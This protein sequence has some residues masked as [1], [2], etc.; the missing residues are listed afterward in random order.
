MPDFAFSA[1]C[2]HLQMS[3]RRRS[4]VHSLRRR[5]CTC[6][7]K[8]PTATPG[9]CHLDRPANSQTSGYNRGTRAAVARSKLDGATIRTEGY[10]TSRFSNAP[11]PSES[12]A[13]DQVPPAV[14]LPPTPVSKPGSS[15]VPDNSTRTRMFIRFAGLA[16]QRAPA[17]RSHQGYVSWRARLVVRNSC[18]FY[19]RLDL[20]RPRRTGHSVEQPRLPV[21]RTRPREPTGFQPI[22]VS[23]VLA[24]VEHPYGLFDV[25]R[26]KR[27]WRHFADLKILETHSSIEQFCYQRGRLPRPGHVGCGSAGL[28]NFGGIAGYRRREGFSGRFGATSTEPRFWASNLDAIIDTTLRWNAHNSSSD[29][30]LNVRSSI[31]A[32]SVVP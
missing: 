13:I 11:Q 7:Q 19:H 25:D 9:Q 23:L 3:N 27:R 14:S 15:P 22:L 20:Q 5:K 26:L 8:K 29:I 4:A 17:I 10:L 21:A 18:R 1:A 2:F 28:R 30:S 6:H 16:V 32:A 31:F 12:S 24:S